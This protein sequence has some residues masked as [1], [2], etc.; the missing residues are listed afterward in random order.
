MVSAKIPGRKID[1]EGDFIV[2]SAAFFVMILNFILTTFIEMQIIEKQ[3]LGLNSNFS[4]ILDCISN[5]AEISLHVRRIQ[6]KSECS[7]LKLYGLFRGH[8]PALAISN[9]VSIGVNRH[10]YVNLIRTTK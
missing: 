5:T 6:N 8:P 9:P 7:K 1:L 3:C 4:H 10:S 2:E